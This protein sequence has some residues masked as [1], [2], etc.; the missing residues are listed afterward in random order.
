MT[1]DELVKREEEA[2]AARK[3]AH[4]AEKV[5]RVV[6]SRGGE[7]VARWRRLQRGQHGRLL[8]GVARAG[9]LKAGGGAA[10]PAVDRGQGTGRVRPRC[11]A[12]GGERM[13]DP[14][15]PLVPPRRGPWWCP[16]YGLDA[17]WR[18]ARQPPPGYVRVELD[19]D[20]FLLWCTRDDWTAYPWLV[21][22]RLRRCYWDFLYLLYRLGCIDYHNGFA[23]SWRR[24]F[25]PWRPLQRWWA[26]VRRE[27]QAAPLLPWCGRAFLSRRA[28]HAPGEWAAIAYW[29]WWSYGA[30]SR[31]RWL[32]RVKAMWRVVW[33][34]LYKHRRC[35]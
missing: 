19:I 34:R 8:P 15:Y 5:Y 31:Y 22:T 28:G 1:V 4:E 21:I 24:H 11:C 2:E 7:A 33:W 18:S 27:W 9:R 12:D 26:R 32:A 6:Y 14:Q 25:R 29:R 30:T 13:S 16:L 23:F 17:Q 3:R 10:T 20:H 35:Y